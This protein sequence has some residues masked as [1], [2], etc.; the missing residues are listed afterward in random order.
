MCTFQYITICLNN[1]ALYIHVYEKLMSN[2]NLQ[3]DLLAND[4]YLV[5]TEDILYSFIDYCIVLPGQ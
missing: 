1:R 2:Y 4:I 5:D 3:V